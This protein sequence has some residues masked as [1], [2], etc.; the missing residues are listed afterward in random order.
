MAGEVKAGP[1]GFEGVEMKIWILIGAL[2]LIGCQKVES[3]TVL[4]VDCTVNN[5]T[6]AGPGALPIKSVGN[7]SDKISFDEKGKSY[8]DEAT[9]S[10]V[11]CRSMQVSLVTLYNHPSREMKNNWIREE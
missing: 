11:E 1:R 2:A 7:I 9:N 8:I 10:W 3:K 5:D 6:N 4:L